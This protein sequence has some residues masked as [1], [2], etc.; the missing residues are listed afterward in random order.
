MGTGDEFV[1]KVKGKA[2]ATGNVDVLKPGDSGYGKKASSELPKLKGPRVETE[3]GFQLSED[4]EPEDF[5]RVIL[6][7]PHNKHGEIVAFSGS[8]KLFEQLKATISK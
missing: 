2:K 1:H 4:D 6:P 7:D 3:K 8:K 5:V